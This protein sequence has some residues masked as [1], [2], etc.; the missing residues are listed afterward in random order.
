MWRDD[1]QIAQS[2]VIVGGLGGSGTRVVA[3]ILQECGFYIGSFLNQQLDNLWFTFFMRRPASIRSFNSP[4][5]IPSLKLF[6][7]VMKSYWGKS[8]NARKQLYEIASEFMLYNYVKR[9]RFRFPLQ[10]VRSISQ[11]HYHSEHLQWGFKEPN[12]HLFIDSLYQIYPKMK[13]VLMLRHPLDMALGYNF[14]QLYNWY[15]LYKL[16]RPNKKNERSLMLKFY[17]AAYSRSLQLGKALPA[18]NFL[19]VKIE[20][21]TTDRDTLDKL[22]RFIGAEVN[23]ERLYQLRQIPTVQPTFGRYQKLLHTI[24]YAAAERISAQFDY[25]IAS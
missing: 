7:A 16:P 9:S 3:Q 6:D 4:V 17:E 21:L 23:S 11:H 25:K 1:K 2:P 5:I 24:D 8:F 14:N 19:V 12:T 15:H 22:I 20:D 18:H 10:A 13:F